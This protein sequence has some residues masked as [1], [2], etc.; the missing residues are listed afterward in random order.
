MHSLT[1]L[2]L[3]LTLMLPATGCELEEQSLADRA[4]DSITDPTDGREHHGP[5]IPPPQRLLHLAMDIGDLHDEPTM[6]EALAVMERAH[7]ETRRAE[8][9]LRE[10]LATAVSEG[11]VSPEAVAAQL[12]AIAVAARSEA[13]SLTLTL[14]VAHGLLDAPS[15]EEVVDALLDAPPPEASE[16][17]PPPP[18][19]AARSPGAPSGES[20]APGAD[21]RPPPGPMG[22]LLHALELDEAQHEALRAA[23]GEPT[24][25]E[26]PDLESFVDDDFA[27]SELGLADALSQRS[28][29]RAGRHVE[30]LAV[31]VSILDAGQLEALVELLEHGPAQPARSAHA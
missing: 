5:P 12:A 13:E 22:H 29:E 28:L 1:T 20:R 11:S 2:T 25:P 9:A 27:A 30:M 17:R 6:T 18:D 23:L 7:Q 19:G 24:P 31:L 4:G 14:D 16:R 10:A 3:A 8:D 26:S 21:R 15:R